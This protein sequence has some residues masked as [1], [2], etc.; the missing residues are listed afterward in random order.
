MLQWRIYYGD[1]S[2]FSD[3]DGSVE[4][5]PPLNVQAIAEAA[6]I[7]IGRRVTARYDYYWHENN[8]FSGG[9]LFG[10]FDYLM[11]AQGS[12]VVKF[13]R[14]VTNLEYDAALQHAVTDPELPTK[15]A[16]HPDERRGWE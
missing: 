6:G 2:T 14:M 4:E 9:D 8:Q 5:A 3:L 13:G 10:L 7:D 15:T 12:A 16:W 11:R 1:G